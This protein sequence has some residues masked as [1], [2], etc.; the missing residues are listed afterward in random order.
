MDCMITYQKQN[1]DII[2]RPRKSPYDRYVG[3][4]TSMGWKV[5]DIH[6]RYENNYYTYED[7]MRLIRKKE[8][9]KKRCLR[10]LA[11]KINKLAR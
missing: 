6:Y 7:F 8:S 4:E 2:F 3:Q 5:I 10:K 9:L 1:G 11:C